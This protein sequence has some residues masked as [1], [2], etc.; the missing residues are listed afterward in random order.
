VCSS[1][2]AMLS[3]PHAA[4]ITCGRVSMAT[5]GGYDSNVIDFERVSAPK[6][7]LFVM[8]KTPECNNTFLD[9][10]VGRVRIRGMKRMVDKELTESTWKKACKVRTAL[11][12]NSMTYGT[13]VKDLLANKPGL[14]DV[15]NYCL[16]QASIEMNWF[17]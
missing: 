7:W 15:L 5:T 14:Q 17:A 16:M 12:T 1:F 2:Y 6:G 4:R 13:I 11:A 3:T 8:A 10:M 9:D